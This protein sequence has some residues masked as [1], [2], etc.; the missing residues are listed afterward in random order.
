MS[1]LQLRA[2][3]RAVRERLGVD[4]PPSQENWELRV[5]NAPIG[6]VPKHAMTAAA[7][8]RCIAHANEIDI[9]EMLGRGRAHR[10]VRARA[11]LAHELRARG[12]SFPRIGRT[13]NRDHTSVINLIANR[14][15]AGVLRDPPPR[16]RQP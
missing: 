10:L 4:A 1:S 14:T 15:P 11:I 13:I 3:Y 2:Q 5:Y 16:F 6:P 7:L 8:A 12:W 9:G